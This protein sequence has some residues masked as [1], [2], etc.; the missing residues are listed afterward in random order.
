MVQ[1][2]HAWST[3]S[4]LRNL[5]QTIVR[6]DLLCNYRTLQWLPL[7]RR[8]AELRWPPTKYNICFRRRSSWTYRRPHILW[9]GTLPRKQNPTAPQ[10]H[11]NRSSWE[12]RSNILAS[13]GAWI[14]HI[15]GHWMQQSR[16][17]FC[18]VL[19]WVG[20]CVPIAERLL[21]SKLGEGFARTWPTQAIKR[22]AAKLLRSCARS[23][24]NRG[25]AWRLT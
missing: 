6:E 10:V 14:S 18:G 16:D 20:K 8:D 22:P 24:Y 15:W 9:D 19:N 4:N 3:S 11:Q 2:L 12:F 5:N 21:P 7:P 23:R 25:T 13:F 1:G 17:I